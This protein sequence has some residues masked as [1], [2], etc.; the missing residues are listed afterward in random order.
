MSYEISKGFP[1]PDLTPRGPVSKYPFARMELGD[2]FFVP[3]EDLPA[4]G[5][6]SIRAAIYSYHKKVKGAGKFRALWV[7]DMSGV[8]VWRIA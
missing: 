6:D 2:S 4:K 3:S 8:R 1:V 5:L 7:G